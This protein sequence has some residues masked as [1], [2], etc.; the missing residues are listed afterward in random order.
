MADEELWKRRFQMF[1]L[2]RLF[3]LAV[4][5]LGIFVIYTDL[6]RPGGWPAVG[7][8]L[9]IMGALDAVLAPK[10]LKKLWEQQ[11]RERQ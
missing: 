8:V 11:D 4:F 2:V 1:M 3:G 5:V 6:L 9:T 7:A 10:M